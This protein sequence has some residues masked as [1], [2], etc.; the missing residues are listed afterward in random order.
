MLGGRG[1]MR[2]SGDG[3]KMVVLMHSYESAYKH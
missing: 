3:M 2:F 1:R